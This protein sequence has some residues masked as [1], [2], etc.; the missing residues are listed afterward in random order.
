[1][2]FPLLAAFTALS[3]ALVA[4]CTQPVEEDTVSQDE[5]LQRSPGRRPLIEPTV[6]NAFVG[7]TGACESIAARRGQWNAALTFPGDA[8]F[9]TFSWAGNRTRADT[10]T[11]KATLGSA[12]V[13]SVDISADAH[14][15]AGRPCV[16]P[17]AEPVEAPTGGGGFATS[18]RSC[19]HAT[20]SN[21]FIDVALPPDMVTAEPSML[22][23]V[24]KGLEVQLTQPGGV[25]AFRV[26][27][28]GRSASLADTV[29]EI[30]V[31]GSSVCW[32]GPGGCDSAP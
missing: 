7:S 18:C 11:L 6:V 24:I 12:G 17:N 30:A 32:A 29:A 8:S 25:S 28:A 23:G 31:K 10:A 27:L 13:A 9:C 26:P 19:I 5:A 4:G 16:R 15:V 20:V 21:G 14:C 3:L 1:M 2:R 22:E